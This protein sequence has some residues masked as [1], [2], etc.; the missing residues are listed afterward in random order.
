MTLRRVKRFIASL[1]AIACTSGALDAAAVE[2]PEVGGETLTIDV[3]NTTEIGYHFNNR[4][5]TTSG[6]T[7]IPNQHVDDFYGDWF[8]RLYIRAYYWKMSFGLRLDSAVFFNTM[9]RGEA[10]QLIVDEL[11]AA[12]LALENDFSREVHSRYTNLI[13]PAKLW[14]GFKHKGIE[15]TAGDFYLQ[16]GRGL[17]FSVRKIDE[18]GIDTTVRG[19]KLKLRKKFDDFR[20]ELTVFGGQ[21]NPIRTDFSTGRIL[22]GDGAGLFFGFPEV[23]DFEYYRSNGA[24]DFSR[25]RDRAK[26]SYLEDNVV[27]ANITVGPKQVQFEANGALLL[28]QSNSEALQRCISRLPG[29]ASTAE[30]AEDLCRATY[31]SFTEP[32]ASRSHDEIRN[33]SG[34]FRIPSIEDTF[35]AYF[36][37]AGQQQTKG[38]VQAIT[39]LGEA[40]R[41]D[42]LWGYAIY[43]NVNLRGGIF[44][45]T[46]QGKHYRGFFPLAAN[47]DLSTKGFGA[48]EYN[49]VNYSESPTTENLYAE[50]IGAPDQCISGGRGRVDAKVADHSAVYAWVGRYVSWSEIDTTNNECVESD[51]LRTDTWDVASGAELDSADGKTHYWGWIGV[52]LADRAEPAPVVP[53]RPDLTEF[54]R[55]EYV[56]YDFNQHLGGDFSVSALGNHRRRAEPDQLPDPWHEGENLLSLNWNP[57]LSFIFGNE[58]QTRPGFPDHYFNGAIQYRSKDGDTWYGMLTDSVRLFVGQRR[59]ALRCVGG[60]CRVFPA[61]EGMKLEVVSRF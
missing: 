27:G 25:A 30:D 21:L 6:G 53:G 5:V 4:N 41:E 44:A 9:D 3:S 34:A 50:P 7:L 52:R 47:I 12:N 57:H 37:V 36:E 13:Y 16:L 11:G 20:G 2:V 33:F 18:V 42:D 28:R 39:P 8:N 22:H 48:P 24:N 59:S 32:D 43:G 38:R 55:E 15:V 17:V 58:Y 26:P 56:R 49:I 45:L 14:L 23:N 29:D 54:Y 1:A 40:T 61:F 60:V 35:D 31:P 10:Q 19:G 51:A 46:L